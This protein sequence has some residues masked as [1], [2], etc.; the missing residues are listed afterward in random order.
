M[1][2]ELA[3]GLGYLWPA[4][5]WLLGLIIVSGPAGNAVNRVSDWIERLIDKIA[6]V[7]WGIGFVGFVVPL[8][9]INTYLMGP[10]AMFAWRHMEI[11][12]LLVALSGFGY[13]YVT[14]T[15]TVVPKNYL[16]ASIVIGV[17]TIFLGYASQFMLNATWIDFK[18]NQGVFYP[19]PYESIIVEG[20][21]TIRFIGHGYSVSPNTIK[22]KAV[23]V[24]YGLDG[25]L[26]RR[27]QMSPSDRYGRPFAQLQFTVTDIH[28]NVK[29]IPV[30][31][32]TGG[33]K[34]IFGVLDFR[35]L[36]D[37]GYYFSGYVE[38]PKSTPVGRLGI[39]LV[40][41]P[42]PVKGK[43][44]M[45]LLHNIDKSATGRFVTGFILGEGFKHFTK[46]EYMVGIRIGALLMLLMS[47]TFGARAAW[48][49]KEGLRIH[50]SEILAGAVV[51]CI[52]W[53]VL[54]WF[55]TADGGGRLKLAL[56]NTWWYVW[57][58]YLF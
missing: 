21:D 46:N 31:S 2:S 42:S 29:V 19:D 16:V 51:F 26:T 49:T 11:Q 4:L 8:M 22:G 1:K 52:A 20:G 39:E 24:V 36:V 15:P 38:I 13:W 28:G 14:K 33:P 7:L 44:Q 23:N 50:I 30:E 10:I 25:D 9:V 45:T 18:L 54:E 53:A 6:A 47:V 41:V 55:V 43:A 48:N 5:P 57:G 34:K 32:I 27:I 17:A 56:N 40:N 37:A 35:T 58:K 3:K 12:I